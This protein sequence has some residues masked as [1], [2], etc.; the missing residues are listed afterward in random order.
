[1][2]RVRHGF[3]LGATETLLDIVDIDFELF[4]LTQQDHVVTLALPT[5]VAPDGAMREGLEKRR[6]LALNRFHIALIKRYPLSDETARVQVPLHQFE[7]LGGI[8]RRNP[9]D[10]RVN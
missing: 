8:E 7:V 5:K 1:M 6:N 10:P 3:V 9:F 2:K 4:G